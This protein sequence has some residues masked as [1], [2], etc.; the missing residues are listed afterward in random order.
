MFV[1]TIRKSSIIKLIL[2]LGC[3]LAGWLL[4]SWPQAAAN[5]I[6][7]GLSICSSIIIP[8]LFP[9]LVL[10]SF[11]VKSG[12]SR[13]I[14]RFL[15]RPT[16]FLFGL[17]GCCA[18][19]IFISFIGGF[20]SGGIAVGE[21][22]E[23]GSIT[24]QQGRRMLSFCVNGGPAFIIS[25]VGA[26]MMGS[27]QYG[28]MLYC[29]HILSSVILGIIQRIGV[30]ESE[31][32]PPQNNGRI[33]NK[34]AL[35]PASAFVESVNGACHSLLLMCGFII[36]FSALL[37]I[38][39]AVGVVKGIESILLKMLNF[40][41]NPNSIT[42][43]LSAFF[44][45]ILEV[46]CGT[47]EAARTGAAAPLLLGMALGWGGLSVHCQIAA[48]LHGKGLVTRGFFFSKFLQ[49]LI[50]GAVS[51]ILFRYIPVAE[52]AFKPLTDAKVVPFTYNPTAAAALLSLC[53]LFLLTVSNPVEIF[54]MRKGKG[55]KN[56]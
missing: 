34:S 21:L 5:G 30:P 19:G 33:T 27:V 9:F 20:P 51:L 39:D 7:R 45:S 48:A 38:C 2:L 52:T 23:N 42:K 3:T 26:G 55:N 56:Q 18:P 17:P 35:T 14:G 28:V 54:K 50:G 53:A 36:L 43:M 16:R 12:L 49:S 15:E 13:S 22:V 37:S 25:A 31:T 1:K 47:V 4:I 40:S 46:S 44:S 8:S 6:S 29:A 11:I 41:W 24:K 32:L 10:S